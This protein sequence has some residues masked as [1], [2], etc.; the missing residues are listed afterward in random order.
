MLLLPS[1]AG[2]CSASLS[3]P[4]NPTT[5]AAYCLLLSRAPATQPLGLLAGLGEPSSSPF[6]LH[7]GQTL[8]TFR[9]RFAP[10]GHRQL[11]GFPRSPPTYHFAPG[12]RQHF[13]HTTPNRTGGRSPAPAP[14][15][16]SPHATA[17]HHALATPTRRAHPPN[18]TTSRPASASPLQPNPPA[19]G[20]TSARRSDSDNGNAIVALA[21]D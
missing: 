16:G 4:L 9:S 5:A 11:L 21:V 20:T 14:A 10:L 19:T 7:L 3:R 15:A 8:R 17:Q 2:G 1:L 18:P 12:K 13:T 6:R